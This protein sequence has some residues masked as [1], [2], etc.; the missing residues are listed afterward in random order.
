MVI[1]IRHNLEQLFRG[2]LNVRYSEA[3]FNLLMRYNIQPY[4]NLIGS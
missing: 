1:L 3:Y 4:Q 2:S